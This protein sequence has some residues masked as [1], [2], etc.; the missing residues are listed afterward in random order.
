MQLKARV[1][2]YTL[3]L[4]SLTACAPIY[5]CQPMQLSNHEGR[6]EDVLIC[7]PLSKIKP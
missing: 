3:L 6:M 1:L 7:A 2:C 5:V 4:L